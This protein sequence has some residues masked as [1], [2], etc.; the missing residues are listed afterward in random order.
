VLL[1]DAR[2][3]LQLRFGRPVHAAVPSIATR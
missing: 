3:L 2:I 1:G